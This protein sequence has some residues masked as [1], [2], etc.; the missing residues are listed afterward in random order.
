M[1]NIEGTDMYK[2][3]EDGRVYSEHSGRYLNPIIVKDGVL[4]VRIKING[5]KKSLAVH[6]LVAIAYVD[7]PDNKPQ[8]DHIDGN[9][10]NNHVNNLRWCT[11]EENQAYRDEQGNSGKERTGKR[12]RWGELLFPS[13]RAAARYIAEL[14]GSKVETVRK[15]LKA[16]RYGEKLLYGEICRLVK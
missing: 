1:K 4:K 5:I 9:K 6:R 3:T 16:V 14:R 8:V 12:I 11:N 2:V 15:E 7:N 10:G 13:I